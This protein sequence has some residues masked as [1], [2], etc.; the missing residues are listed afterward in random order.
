MSIQRLKS[1]QYEEAIKLSMY[2]FQY[3]VQDHEIDKRKKMLDK[4]QIIGI[5]EEDRLASKLHMLSL[6]ISINGHDWKMGGIA[7]VATYP[8][9]RRKGHVKELIAQSLKEMKSKGEVFSFLHPFDIGFYRKYGWEIFAENKKV[10]IETKDLAM[11]GQLAGTIKRVNKSGNQ[12]IEQMYKEYISHYS[13][14][15]VRDQDWW[16]TSIYSHDDEIAVFTNEQGQETGYMIYEI[17]D[18]VMR[19][20]EYVGLDQEARVQLWNFICQHDSMLGKV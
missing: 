7:G 6:Q 3:K 12:S 10:I 16:K 20:S 15:L 1:D 17:Q 19:V 8:E 9:Y 14:G 13:G 2:A 4:Q 5:W 18:R 11:I